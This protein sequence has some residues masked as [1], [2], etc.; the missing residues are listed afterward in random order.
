M[1]QIDKLIKEILSLDE[2][3]AVITGGSAGIG[4]ATA[5][6]FARMGA[7]WPKNSKDYPFTCV[8]KLAKDLH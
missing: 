1:R 7:E 3:R 4:A 6:L 2:K 8:L 5:R